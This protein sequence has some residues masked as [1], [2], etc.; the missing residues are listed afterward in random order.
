VPPERLTLLVFA[1][2]V[3]VL[4][5]FLMAA[6]MALWL[7][8]GLLTLYFLMLVTITRLRAEAGFP[9][10][11]GPHRWAG[12]TVTD[13]MGNTLGTG[14]FAPSQLT[15]AGFFHWLWW[16]LRFAQMPG[17]FE[18]LKIGE[19]ARIRQQQL[20]GWI[21]LA[22]IAA[23]LTGMVAGLWNGYHLGWATAKTY[24]GI[25]DGARTGYELANRW[26]SN[27]VR[28]DVTRSVVSLLGAGVTMAL[29]VARQR[30]IWW[31]FNPI[32]YV[33][34]A[35]N[36]ATMFWS[37]YFVAW[38]LKGCLLRYGGMRFYRAAVPFFIG[39]ILGDIA[40]QAVWSLFS[41]ILDVPVYQFLV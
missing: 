11:Y 30:F 24:A 29:I 17:Q 28:P 33:M 18:A 12:G 2:A 26:W 3:A 35:T 39:L 15:A 36:T 22:T 9:W 10:V 16:D 5:A 8:V 32:G 20:V 41:S 34:G 27:P 37:D 40:T 7:A 6:G 31:P 21:V 1:A 13:M 4:L 38:I 14:F 25:A 23:L 19:V